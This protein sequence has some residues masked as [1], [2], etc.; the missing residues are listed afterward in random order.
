MQN[1]EFLGSALPINLLIQLFANPDKVRNSGT[2]KLHEKELAEIMVKASAAAKELD[3]QSLEAAKHLMKDR[4]DH[5]R[6]I[7]EKLSP[8]EKSK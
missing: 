8:K 2:A 4:E 3:A 1:K 7:F 6:L 5:A